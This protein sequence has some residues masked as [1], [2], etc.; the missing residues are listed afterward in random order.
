M[1]RGLHENIAYA[2]IQGEKTVVKTVHFQAIP[3]DWIGNCQPG[4]H[5]ET[6]RDTL[7]MY[8]NSHQRQSKM[9][10]FYSL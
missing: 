7:L 10:K 1:F 5:Q 8:R 9:G 6:V 2:F 4:V 3:A